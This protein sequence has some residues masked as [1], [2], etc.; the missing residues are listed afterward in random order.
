[1]EQIHPLLD[2]YPVHTQEAARE[3]AKLAERMPAAQSMRVRMMS[4]REGVRAE[5][6]DPSEAQ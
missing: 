6:D 4:Q 3:L 5:R 2:I 1:M